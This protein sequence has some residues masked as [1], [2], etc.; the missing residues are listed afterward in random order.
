MNKNDT[1]VKTLFVGISLCLVCSIIISLTAV[2]LRD[3]QKLLKLKDQQSKILS[4]AGLL[5]EQ[6]SIDELFITIEERVINLETGEYVDSIDPKTFNGKK[7]ESEDYSKDL[8][9]SIQ[10]KSDIDISSL[11]RRENFIKVY[12]YKED[13]N[14]RAVILPVRGLGL[15]GTLYGYLAI[16]PDLN[17][18]IGLEYFSHK[19]TPGLGAEVDNPRWKT[20][21]RGKKIRS[22]TGEFKIEVI[23]GLVS[24]ESPESKYQVDGLSGA[25]ITSRG[26]SN[27][28]AF[29]LGELGYEK[30]L[31]K[32]KV[33]IEKEEALNV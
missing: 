17:T 21:W 18:I 26:V 6:K 5:T 16:E 1:L 29:W 30:F 9:T 12:L 2:G 7:F 32:L 27:M 24:P 33:E 23:K 28:L 13:N 19:E 22:S 11:K 14:I 25:T 8:T 15:W 3:Q 10:L 4:S 31:N 20:K